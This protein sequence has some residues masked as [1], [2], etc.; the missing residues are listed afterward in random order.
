[1]ILGAFFKALSQIGY[2]RFRQVL[3]LGVGLTFALFLAMFVVVFHL[4]GWIFGSTITLPWI[5]EITWIG[6]ALSWASVPLMTVAS[7]FLMVPVASAFTSLFLDRVADA[8]EQR[9]YPSLPPARAPGVLEGLRD[10]VRFL[11]VLIVANLLALI[12]YVIFSAAAPFIFWIMNGYLLGVE[13]FHL[14]A[15]RRMGRPE[16][17]RMRKAH[18]GKIWAAGTLMALPLSIPFV[19]LL[20]PI[21]GAAT[22]VHIFHALS[23]RRPNLA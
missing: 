19:N 23:K 10:S 12:A 6:S 22:F 11:G 3:F 17:I 7:V 2:P 1:M 5:G 9:Y 14:A 20:I 13:Y 15:I 4:V 16:A 8:V 18:I 21:L